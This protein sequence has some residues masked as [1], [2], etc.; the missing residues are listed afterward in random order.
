MG[1]DAPRYHTA[2]I[3]P[4]SLY[5]FNLAPSIIFFF[6]ATNLP[7]P[8]TNQVASVSSRIGLD[9]WYL[10]E[11]LHDELLHLL[12]RHDWSTLLNSTE[13]DNVWNECLS[14]LLGFIR[15]YSWQQK[16]SQRRWATQKHLMC[17]WVC[18]GTESSYSDDAFHVHLHRCK[19]HVQSNS[20]SYEVSQEPVQC[21]SQCQSIPTQL[22][23]RSSR[24]QISLIKR[25]GYLS[26]VNIIF[27]RCNSRSRVN[28]MLI[29]VVCSATSFST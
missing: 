12:P 2:G 19:V 25:D 8:A 21:D 7:M 10:Q 22:P 4:N 17:A 27:W 24:F 16:K 9:W 15:E 23:F 29:I 28:M 26:S 11:T 18:W 5:Q 6:V 3:K 13:C 1:L 20:S 14:A